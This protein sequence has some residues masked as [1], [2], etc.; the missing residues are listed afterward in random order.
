LI[1]SDLPSGMLPIVPMDACGADTQG[2]IGL[3]YVAAVVA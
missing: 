1:R 2:T 3:L